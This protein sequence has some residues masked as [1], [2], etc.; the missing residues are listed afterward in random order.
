MALSENL[1]FWLANSQDPESKLVVYRF[2]VVPFGAKSSPFILNSVIIRHLEGEQSSTARDMHRSVF[3]DNIIT[4]CENENQALNYYTQAKKIMRR[5]NLPLQA[6]GFSSEGLE[7][8][9][10]NFGDLDPSPV[11]KT[12]GLSWDQKLDSLNVQS[13]D[14]LSYSS[15]NASMRDVLRGVASLYDPLGFYSPLTIS[16]KIFL[17]DLHEEKIKL[18]KVMSTANLKRWKEIVQIRS[19]SSLSQDIISLHRH[20]IEN[21]TFSAMRAA[22]PM[23]PLPTFSTKEKWH[24]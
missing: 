9:L 13:V 8:K 21:F 1:W 3:V 17:Q 18:D 15:E 12:I 24:L 16:G 23:A 22:V 14:L 4:G 2:K 10:T 20:L 6:W 5:A 7:N 19:R 11:S